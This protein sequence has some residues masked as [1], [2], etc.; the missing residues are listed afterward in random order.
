MDIFAR[1]VDPKLFGEILVQLYSLLAD[2]VTPVAQVLQRR[3]VKQKKKQPIKKRYLHRVIKTGKPEP[4]CKGQLDENPKKLRLQRTP[5]I[6]ETSSETITEVPK[7]SQAMDVLKKRHFLTKQKNVEAEMSDLA[8]ET[9]SLLP[10]TDSCLQSVRSI[11]QRLS[12]EQAIPD[13]VQSNVTPEEEL[14]SPEDAQ[15]VLGDQVQEESAIAQE[16]VSEE[17]VVTED[18]SEAATKLEGDVEGHLAQPIRAQYSYQM[19][20]SNESGNCGMPQIPVVML[21]DDVLS[22]RSVSL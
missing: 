5:R 21:N 22:L 1:N 12:D 4:K 3:P 17:P 14:I 13:S 2:D 19:T 10:S 16:T 8:G 15:L 20:Y 9:E 6:E 11:T 18:D 7:F